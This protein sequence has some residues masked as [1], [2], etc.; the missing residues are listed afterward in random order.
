MTTYNLPDKALT[1]FQTAHQQRVESFMFLAGQEVPVAPEI[2]DAKVRELR[3]R[4][5]LEE[6]LETIKALGFVAI[7][8]R[9]CLEIEDITFLDNG[10]ACL[11]EIA[12]GCADLSVVAIGTLS[13]CGIRDASLLQLVDES[14]LAKFCGDAHKREDGKWV[15]PSDWTKPPIAELLEL[16]GYKKPEKVSQEP[17][18][19]VDVIEQVISLL[20]P[21]E[22]V[23]LREG[24]NSVAKS[25]I[26]AP[27]ETHSNL[28]RRASRLLG[29]YLGNPDVEWKS[30]IVELWN[31]K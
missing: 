20:P 21:L 29:Y 12:D 28:W 9:D 10:E 16:Q 22:Y 18:N 11:E 26:Y 17:R 27:P 13:A 4:L 7:K 31:A 25:A 19:I 1:L 8:E 5:I 30:K 24:L 2:P 3:C 23:A 14:N 15:K 6:A